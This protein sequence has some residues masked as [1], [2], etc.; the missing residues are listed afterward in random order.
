[1]RVL[2]LSLVILVVDQLTKVWVVQTF[3]PGL[4]VPV[5]GDWLKFTFTT[6][7]GMAF[8]ME[9]GSKLFLSLFSIVATV[10]IGV[11]LWVIR[12]APLGYRL[13]LAAII[14]GAMGN[15]IDRTFYGVI[16]GYAP[17]FYGEVVDFI[18]VD[19]YRGVLDLPLLG[20]R[21]V[22]LFPIWNVAD[23]GITLGVV[24]ILLLQ[25]RFQRAMEAREKE[26]QTASDRGTEPI[27]D[28]EPVAAPDLVADPEP[29]GGM[30]RPIGTSRTA[31]GPDAEL[32]AKES[33][34]PDATV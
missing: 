26:K 24:A 20:E 18:H 9:L 22:A 3:D 16:Y 31:P 8:G 10:A 19:V 13:A 6:N 28:P 4:S 11:Y 15:V 25:G 30:D 27:T 32:P 23:R 5:L 2:W 17:L 12:E 21:F 14:G 33:R 34:R 29:V 7:P 1:M